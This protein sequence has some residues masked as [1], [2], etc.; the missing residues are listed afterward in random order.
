VSQ[1][2]ILIDRANCPD[3]AIPPLT[4][5]GASGAPLADYP[6]TMDEATKQQWMELCAR[7]EVCD[8]PEEL[9]RLANGIVTIL[10]R[11]GRRLERRSEKESPPHS[12]LPDA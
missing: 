5:V 11:E 10:I 4:L 7:V 1:I 3:P 12:G 6:E 9:T 2:G 8:C